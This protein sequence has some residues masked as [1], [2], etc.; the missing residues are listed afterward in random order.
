MKRPLPPTFEELLS[1]LPSEEQMLDGMTTEE[2][3]HHWGVGYS[4][5]RKVIRAAVESKK[6]EL[7]QVTR[8]N[9][10]RPGW[11]VKHTVFRIRE[12]K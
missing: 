3:K 10:M 2:W 9:P 8:V 1:Q 4:R 12:E 5:A 11:H 6:M 7:G